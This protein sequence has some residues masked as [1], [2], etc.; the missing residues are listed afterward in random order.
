MKRIL[1]FC[2]AVLAIACAP[3]ETLETTGGISGKITEAGTNNPISAVTVSISNVGQQYNTGDDGMYTFRQLPE[4]QYTVTASKPGYNTMQKQFIIRAGQI[5]TGDFALEQTY[6]GLELSTK[7]LDFG[8]ESDKMTF[9]ILKQEGSASLEWKIEKQSNATWVSFSETSGKLTAPRTT[10][11]VY[12]DRTKLTSEELYATDIIIRSKSGGATTLRVTAMKKGAMI[13][14]TPTSLDFGTA[15]TERTII[16]KNESNEGVISFKATSTESWC[17][18]VGGEGTLSKGAVATIKVT[19]NRTKL[20]P[21]NYNGTILITSTRNTLTIPISMVIVAKSRPE[22]SNLQ[23]TEIRHSSINASAYISSVGSSAITAYGFCWSQTNTQPTTSD[24][25]NSL[26]GTTA[27]KAFNSTLTSLTPNTFYYVRAYAINAE[28]VAYS[29]PI[30]IKTLPPPTRPVI[31]TLKIEN[32]QHNKIEVSG[33]ITDLGDGFVT[34]HGFVYSKVNNEPTI[35]DAQLDLGSSTQVGRFEGS[36]SGLSEE[37]TYYVRAYARNGVGISYGGTLKITTKTAPPAVLDGLLAYYTFDQQNCD[38]ELGEIDFDG[39]E[40]GSGT[41]MSYIKDTPSGKSYALKG[42]I[43]G[44]WYKILRAPENGQS[45]VTYSAWVKTKATNSIFYSSSR[46]YDRWEF[47]VH[48]GLVTVYRYYAGS[49]IRFSLQV[50]NILCN[51]SWHHLVVVRKSGQNKLYIDGRHYET[52]NATWGANDA[53][54]GII[55]N[56][57]GTMDNLRIYNRELTAEEIKEL[58]RNKQ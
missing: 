42:S 45:V 1:L 41:E 43:N 24:N 37:T 36:I 27:N 31:K 13:V 22:I 5:N 6:A 10:I 38:D 8:M 47:G 52:G 35:S 15:E 54:Y 14:A 7:T 40:Q 17:N 18:I 32:L 39:V 29:H 4:G 16:I 23:T 9:D 21:A 49:R 34:A 58:Y 53:S 26:G 33:E 57:D 12:L 30:Q 55:G 44:K 19:V 56:F 50:N 48:E 11:T 3:E 28:G 25:H 20:T 46:G 51:G 2:I